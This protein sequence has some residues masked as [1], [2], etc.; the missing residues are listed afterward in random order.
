VADV[1]QSLDGLDL[2]VA[3]FDCCAWWRVAVVVRG[4]HSVYCA[5]RH[6]RRLGSGI[7]LKRD[8][9][10]KFHKKRSNAR[11]RLL[12]TYFLFFRRINTKP[13]KRKIF[14]RP[15][16]LLYLN[17]VHVICYFVHYLGDRQD[18]QVDPWLM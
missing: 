17:Y 6:S 16:L 18:V 1:D 9:W 13:L 7:I 2:S 14:Q 10:K 11:S 5:L 8:I 12:K 15:I 3:V 4:G